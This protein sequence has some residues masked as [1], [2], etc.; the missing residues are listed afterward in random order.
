MDGVGG[1]LFDVLFFSFLDPGYHHRVIWL[2][3]PHL[4]NYY[5]RGWLIFSIPLQTIEQAAWE[6]ETK[7]GYSRF[8][9]G[10]ASERVVS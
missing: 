4:L 9:A 2:T 8:K 3:V 1:I 10:K 6:E 7:V 5:R